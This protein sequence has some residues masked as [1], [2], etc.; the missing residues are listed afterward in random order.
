VKLKKINSAKEKNKK[1]MIGIDIK[2]ETK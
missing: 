2:N 1:I